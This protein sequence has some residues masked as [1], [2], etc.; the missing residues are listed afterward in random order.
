MLNMRLTKARTFELD[1][2]KSYIVQVKE[3]VMDE[4]TMQQLVSAMA[5]FKIKNVVFV[6]MPKGKSL[7]FI[8]AKSNKNKKEKK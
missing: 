3:D 2:D 6:R 1:P 4:T 7:K 5:Q 8:E